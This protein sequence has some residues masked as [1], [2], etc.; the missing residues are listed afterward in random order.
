MLVGR[1]FQELSFGAL[2]IDGLRA[3]ALSPVTITFRAFRVSATHEQREA[4]HHQNAMRPGKVPGTHR[5]LNL[6]VAA[7]RVDSMPRSLAA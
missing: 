7:I 1:A 6:S 4:D 5:F 3:F 2:G